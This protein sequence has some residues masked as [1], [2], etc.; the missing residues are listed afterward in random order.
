MNTAMVIKSFKPNSI[1]PKKMESVS[2][3]VKKSIN[4]REVKHIGKYMDNNSE[5][6]QDVMS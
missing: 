2:S 5:N 3:F 1:L 6:R 4:E